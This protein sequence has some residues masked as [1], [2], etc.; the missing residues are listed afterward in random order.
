MKKSLIVIVF[1][2]LIVISL[3]IV[4]V[5]VANRISTTGIEVSKMQQQI[6]AYR[7][8]NAILK[9][10]ILK[11]ASFTEIASKAGELGF[12]EAKNSTFLT[13]PLPLAKR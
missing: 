6:K 12:A 8:T 1:V 7:H 5:I 10:K 3:S 13:A 2:L 11:E 4:Q 9:E